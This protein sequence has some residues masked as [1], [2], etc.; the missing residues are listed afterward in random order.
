M[1]VLGE[2]V[3]TKN[4]DSVYWADTEKVSYDAQKLDEAAEELALDD[5]GVTAIDPPD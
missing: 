5:R 4:C 2:G 1:K 3:D